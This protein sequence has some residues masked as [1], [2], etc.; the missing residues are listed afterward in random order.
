MLPEVPGWICMTRFA[1]F[2][3]A[4]LIVVFAAWSVVQVVSG[5]GE[6]MER[7]FN[8]SH[9]DIVDVANCDG[10]GPREPAGKTAVEC[11][12]VCVPPIMA[13]FIDTPD[14]RLPLLPSQVLAQDFALSVGRSYA[15]D[16][17]P[18]RFL[19]I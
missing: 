15:P 16:P 3:A 19:L 14:V 18:P 2:L 8:V 4:V 1:P 11:H 13:D 6:Q 7:A 9:D 5:T 12:I 17:H 10:C